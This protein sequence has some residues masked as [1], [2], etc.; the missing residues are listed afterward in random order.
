MV[1]P[2]PAVGSGAGEGVV[3]GNAVELVGDDEDVCM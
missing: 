2:V 1:V 3:S